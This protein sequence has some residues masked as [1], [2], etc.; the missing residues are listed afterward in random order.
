M[1]GG[2]KKPTLSQ[3]AKSQLKEEAKTD[4]KSSKRSGPAATEKK[5]LRILSPDL[6]D[7]SIIK[8]IEKMKVLTPYSVASRFNIRLSVAKDFLEELQRKGIIT[9][10]YGGGNVKIYRPAVQ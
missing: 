8:E 9:F 7:K 1:G 2:K 6:D 5:T 4:S 3:L 10:V